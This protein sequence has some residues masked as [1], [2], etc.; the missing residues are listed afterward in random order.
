MYL[1]RIICLLALAG[2]FMIPA[3]KTYSTVR[4]GE[5]LQNDFHWQG[6]VATGRALEINAIYGNIHAEATSSSEAEVIATRHSQVSDPNEVQIQQVQHSGGIT[7]CAV[8][9]SDDP[10]QPN[11]C[12]P[13]DGKSHVH[14]NDVRVDFTVKVPPGV[15][16]IARTINGDI[17]ASSLGG[18]VEAYSSLGNIRIS[19]TGYAQAKS[20]SGS[21]TATMGNADWSGQIEF[22]TVTGEIAI[23]LPAK[24]N[25]ELH[26]ETVTGI[27]STEFPLTVQGSSGHRDMNGVIGDGGR[28]L[29][30][31]TISGAI[32]LLRET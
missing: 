14:N 24:S 16:L 10:K 25:T 6:V 28:K 21:I 9:P 11:E 18:N 4:S 2:I 26:A 7:I 27:I 12:Q 17:V 8:Y 32:K 15:R 1:T 5:I 31:K 22:E 19:T 13:G 3:E 23:R 20:V 30:L 29:T